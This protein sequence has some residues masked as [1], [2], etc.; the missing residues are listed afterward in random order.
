MCKLRKGGLITGN[1]IYNYKKTPSTVVDYGVMNEQDKIDY[2]WFRDNILCKSQDDL[3]DW[4]YKFVK[5]YYFNTYIHNDPNNFTF[6]EGKLPLLVVAHLDTVH[7]TVP[8]KNTICVSD[9]GT[10]MTPYGIGGDDRCGV[11]I[12]CQLILKGYRPSVLFV[13][14]E[15]I[16]G[17]GTKEFIKSRF[18]KLRVWKKIKYM[19]EFDRKGDNDCVFYDND[20]QD[21]IDY[22]ESF[23]WKY[24]WGS[25]SDIADLGPETGIASVNLSSAYWEA[26]HDN[27]YINMV[28]LNNI[29]NRASRL[30][31][32][33]PNAEYFKHVEKVYDYKNRYCDYDDRYNYRDNDATLRSYGYYYDYKTH[34]YK[35]IDDLKKEQE[36]DVDDEAYAIV[37]PSEINRN[38]TLKNSNNYSAVETKKISDGELCYES[39]VDMRVD[40]CNS[41]TYRCIDCDEV[42]YGYECYIDDEGILRSPCCLSPVV[43]VSCEDGRLYDYESIVEYDKV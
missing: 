21:F 36:K 2:I 35:R 38:G 19:V 26:H 40:Y 22:I 20:N 11:Y 39:A 33:L 25:Y 29:V 6:V 28:C 30:I 8:T 24:D 31:D 37:D 9:N 32:D 23:G 3:H 15:E 43:I 16:G 27:T 5:N 34:T 4:V 7:D 18:M 42:Y 13:R 41:N 12:I 17:V 1:N 10:I 14:D